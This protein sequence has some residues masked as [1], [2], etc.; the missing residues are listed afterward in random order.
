MQFGIINLT[1]V[2]YIQILSARDMSERTVI[3]QDRIVYTTGKDVAEQEYD[4]QEW[5]RRF[6]DISRSD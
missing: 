5:D 6:N 2:W 3:G 4:T 1:P